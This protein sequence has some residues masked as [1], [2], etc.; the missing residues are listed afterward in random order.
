MGTLTTAP[1]SPLSPTLIQFSM[2][3]RRARAPCAC[4]S[5]ATSPV[6]GRLGP[7]GVPPFA[8]SERAPSPRSRSVAT[9]RLPAQVVDPAGE[10]KRHAEHT[11]G[12]EYQAGHDA[13][14]GEGDGQPDHEG[15]Y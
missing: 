4:C 2:V 12:G 3:R 11:G 13:E 6:T 8:G 1:A 15:P 5:G 7:S 9:G 10:A 14:Q